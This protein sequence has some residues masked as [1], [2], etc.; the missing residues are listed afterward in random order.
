M[1]WGLAGTSK[2]ESSCTYT[3]FRAFSTGHFKITPEGVRANNGIWQSSGKTPKVAAR[4]RLNNFRRFC[5]FKIKG[6]M[7]TI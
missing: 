7:Q 5:H 1:R 6:V 3:A 2:A 4:L